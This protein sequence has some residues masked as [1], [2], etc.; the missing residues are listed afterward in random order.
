[1]S[2]GG[3]ADWVEKNGVKLEWDETCGQY[4]GELR[5]DSG[6]LFQIWMEDAKSMQ[7]K[8]EEV[9]SAGAGGIACW[10]LGLE[11]KDMWEILSAQ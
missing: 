1:M 7:L 10:R 4:T 6:D 9:R 2:Q 11:T 5:T 8:K 3:A